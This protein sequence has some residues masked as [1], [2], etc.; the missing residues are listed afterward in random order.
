[1]LIG[2]SRHVDY[3]A[4][5]DICCHFLKL[6]AAGV[7]VGMYSIERAYRDGAFNN[8]LVRN[9]T[10]IACPRNRVAADDVFYPRSAGLDLLSDCNLT[11][12]E[13]R[14]RCAGDL[15]AEHL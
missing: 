4:Y 3:L 5:R 1:M 8:S 2:K 7:L 6:V 13:Y 11:V 10:Y 9:D 15:P 14:L 12:G